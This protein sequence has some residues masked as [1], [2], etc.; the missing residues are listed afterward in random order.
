MTPRHQHFGVY[1]LIERRGTYLLVEK[2]RGPYTGLLDLPGG[3]PEFGEDL[4]HALVRELDEELGVQVQ[5][6]D[7]TLDRAIGFVFEAPDRTLYHKAV[8]YRYTGE[9]DR[10]EPTA[11][12][13][14]DTGGARWAPADDARLSPLTTAAFAARR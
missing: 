6:G 4:V 2:T 14:V 1:A 8:I 10:I 3:A 13:S 9:V 5:A 12:P 7:L 11:T